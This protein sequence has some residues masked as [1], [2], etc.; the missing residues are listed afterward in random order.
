M[1]GIPVIKAH[2]TVVKAT[3][4]MNITLHVTIDSAPQH[5]SIYW[6]KC[7]GNATEIIHT[8]TVGTSGGTVSSPSLTILFATASNVGIY[9]CYA[10]NV[11][12]SGSSVNI[13]LSV[14]GGKFICTTED[15]VWFKFLSYFP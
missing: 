11:I 10:R 14:E 4:G 8:G 13:S 1:T 7:V 5:F 9:K 12:G 2:E 15:K 3:F 6:T